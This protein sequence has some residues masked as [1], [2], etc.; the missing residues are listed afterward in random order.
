[1]IEPW[2]G[3]AVLCLSGHAFGLG[4]FLGTQYVS[5]I[6]TPESTAWRPEW[7]QAAIDTY[8]RSHRRPLSADDL[9]AYDWDESE[10]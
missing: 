3:L 5:S 6:A 2:M 4:F 10:W 8:Q 7:L 9:A 1:M